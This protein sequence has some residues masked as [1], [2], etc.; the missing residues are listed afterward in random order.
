MI[1][2]NKVYQRVLAFANKEQRGYITPQEFNIFA[3]NA[4][5]EIFEQYFYDLAQYNRINTKAGNSYEY[6][7]I[8][9]NIKEKISIF[10]ATASANLDT[11]NQTNIDPTQAS[12]YRLGTV[13]V[14]NATEVEQ[15]D[16]NELLYINKSRLTAP[17]E[18]RPIYVQNFNELGG[19]TRIIVY[20]LNV[21]FGQV[22]FEYIRKPQ[23]PRWGF[24][25]LGGKALHNA[26]DSVNFEL[27]PSDETELI[28]KI[29]KYAG[30][31]MVREDLSR[32]GQGLESMQIQQEKQ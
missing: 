13:M 15:V 5:L 17:T 32:G 25:V 19:V 12:V 10:K 3:E 20:P 11:E 22:Q 23:R 16:N 31:A 18:S 8:Q 6:A 21:D 26:S 27:H 24:Y 28:Y 2:I 29:L 30:I 9:D 7:D 4:Q 1:N 14:N